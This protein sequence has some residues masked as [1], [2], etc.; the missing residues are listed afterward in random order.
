MEIGN[1]VFIQY[2][3]VGDGEFEELSQKNVDFGGG[4]ER[5]QAAKNDDPDVFKT[6][7]FEKTISNLEG[8]CDLSY[9]S[10]SETKIT[11]R[12]VADHMR[13]AVFLLNSGVIPMNKMQG[14]VLRRLIRRS[15]V[16]LRLLKEGS[17]N[18]LTQ[19]VKD[20]VHSYQG[21]G[22]FD[23]NDIFG[24]EQEIE[25]EVKKFSATLSKG[26][27]EVEK[28]EQIDAKKA[29]DLYQTFGFPIEITAELFKQKGQQID[30]VDFQKEFDS[31]KELSRT[32]SAGNKIYL[33]FF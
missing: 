11:Y 1:S 22:Y 15:V 3:K 14:Y 19:L 28:I 29:F 17:E 4:L 24:F 2:K 18:V 31:H 10:N 30:M 12:I 32:A 5:I 16:K 9:D 13:A 27:K 7:F 20:I 21:S 8:Y 23:E 26:L 6:D 33:D 25:K